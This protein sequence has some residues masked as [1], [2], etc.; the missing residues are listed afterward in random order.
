MK[1]IVYLILLSCAGNLIG[2]Q[3]AIIPNSSVVMEQ[4]ISTFLIAVREGDVGKV[5]AFLACFPDCLRANKTAACDALFATVE[6]CF[7]DAGIQSVRYKRIIKLLEA[8]GAK[9][10]ERVANQMFK[11]GLDIL[12]GQHTAHLQALRDHAPNEN[13]RNYYADAT[14]DWLAMIA[15]IASKEAG[16]IVPANAGWRCSIV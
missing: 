4:N 16:S 6:G 13:M 3:E 2:M 10:D 8:Y 7:T 9:I 1:K 11:M 12:I 15:D 14:Q 5:E